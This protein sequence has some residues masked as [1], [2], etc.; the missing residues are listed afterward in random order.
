MQNSFFASSYHSGRIMLASVS[1]PER[2]DQPIFNRITKKEKPNRPKIIDGIPAK[3]SVPK[4]TIL[5]KAPS[6]V[7]SV[8]K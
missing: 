8:R 7:Y 5:E 1:A 2:I 4:R 3:L 6:R